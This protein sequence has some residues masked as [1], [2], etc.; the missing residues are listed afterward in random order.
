[1]GI[2]LF[3]ILEGFN[4]VCGSCAFPVIMLS[5]FG[6]GRPGSRFGLALGTRVF[7]WA[8]LFL[9]PGEWACEPY[10]SNP[11]SR[12]GFSRTL[13]LEFAAMLIYEQI[14][15]NTNSRYNKIIKSLNKI[16]KSLIQ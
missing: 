14:Y 3:S 8:G 15:I 7:H 6:I 12:F 1:M 4:L 16:C 9:G 13:T 2:I 5:S 11:I 10:F